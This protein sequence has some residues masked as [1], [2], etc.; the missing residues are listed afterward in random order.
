MGSFQNSINSQINSMVKVINEKNFPLVRFLMK[1]NNQNVIVEMKTDEVVQ[2]MIY[3][4]ENTMNMH[5]KNVKFT[6]R[7]GMEKNFKTMC[8]RGSNIRFI[9]LPENLQIETILFD[10]RPKQGKPRNRPRKG[11]GRSRG[12]GRRSNRTRR[13]FN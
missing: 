1:L 7:F 2:G 4:V 6:N 3:N 8:L 9:I 12:R 11:R 5:L 13:K 10:D